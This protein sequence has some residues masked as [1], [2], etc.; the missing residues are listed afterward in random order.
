MEGI[1]STEDLNCAVSKPNAL[2]GAKIRKQSPFIQTFDPSRTF[3]IHRL[4]IKPLD[5]PIGSV[6]INLYGVPSSEAVKALNWSVEFPAG[7]HDMLDV[8]LKE[9]SK[10]AWTGLRRMEVWADFRYNDVEMGDWEFCIDD[11]E[12]ELE[13]SLQQ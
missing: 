9:F 7:F 1:I 3:A 12:I 4:K 10:V 11:L 5:L 2:Y 13:S 6:T 8:K